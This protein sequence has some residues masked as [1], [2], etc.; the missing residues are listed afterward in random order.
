[1]SQRQARFWCRLV[2]WSR[3]VWEGLEEGQEEVVGVLAELLE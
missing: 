3:E 1:M 2:A